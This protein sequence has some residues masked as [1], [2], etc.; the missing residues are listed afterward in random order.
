MIMEYL[1]DSFP[2][3]EGHSSSRLLPAPAGARA[4]ARIQ[5]QRSNELISAFFTYLSNKDEV[6]VVGRDG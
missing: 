3:E 6:Y 5:A 4:K 1:V 2:P